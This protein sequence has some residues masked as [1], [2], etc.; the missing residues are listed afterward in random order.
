MS[1]AFKIVDYKP[2][3]S[4]IFK[5][6]LLHVASMESIAPLTSEQGL[7]FKALMCKAGAFYSNQELIAKLQKDNELL[8]EALNN[9]LNDC[10]NFDG[11]D[12][13][14]CHLTHAARILKET[15]KD[16]V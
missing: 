7:D 13:S 3:E 2:F 1:N 5:F 14:D 6:T 9:L 15:N 11:G 12:L 4:G 16:L 8:R 10:I